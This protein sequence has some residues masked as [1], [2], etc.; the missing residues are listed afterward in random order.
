MKNDPC[1]KLFVFVPND[2][3]FT[4]T[5]SSVFAGGKVVD[6]AMFCTGT[7]SAQTEKQCLAASK[8]ADTSSSLR[9]ADLGGVCQGVE[10]GHTG[11]LVNFGAGL[12]AKVECP[13]VCESQDLDDVTLDWSIDFSAGVSNSSN[14]LIATQS[15]AAY[16]NV[17]DQDLDKSQFLS[18]TDQ[19]G[20]DGARNGDLPANSDCVL[21]LPDIGSAGELKARLDTC[22]KFLNQFLVVTY[23]PDVLFL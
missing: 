11:A 21:P 15:Q 9:R 23:L 12:S 20:A 2:G 19:C 17:Q 16:E 4:G 7:S 8:Q 14:F 18:E 10:E 13:A 1:D 6:T 3:A 22:G 5:V